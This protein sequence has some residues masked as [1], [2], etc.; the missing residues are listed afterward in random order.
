MKSTG[1]TPY[2]VILAAS[3]FSAGSLAMQP[4]APPPA[5]PAPGEQD[6][7]LPPIE[8]LPSGDYRLGEIV[9]NKAQRSI[10]FPAEVNMDRGLLEYLLVHRRGKTHES[11][12]RTRVEPYSLQIAFLL[13][14]FAGSEEKLGMQGDVTVPKGDP[15]RI[16]LKSAAG[17]VGEEFPPERWLVNVID[18]QARDV[19]PMSWVY[20]GS[21]IH[22]GRFLAQD[23]GSMVAIWHDPAALMDNTTPGGESNRIW[24][25]RQG[26]VPPVG[27]PV[28][29]VIRPAR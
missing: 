7:V 26:T 22:Y 29:V 3:V 16:T 21:M 9:V 25:V 10:T 19:P 23:S 27:T 2:A 4:A 5:V 11:L 17:G 18:G 13:L 20:T 1:L 6:Q 14:D 12:L 24:F 15:I 8:K 28:E